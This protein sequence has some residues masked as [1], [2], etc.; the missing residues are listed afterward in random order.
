MACHL[1]TE[2]TLPSNSHRPTISRGH[3]SKEKDSD[4]TVVREMYTK[5]KQTGKTKKKELLQQVG[6]N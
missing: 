3:R 1:V 4:D 6:D 2:H 5:K